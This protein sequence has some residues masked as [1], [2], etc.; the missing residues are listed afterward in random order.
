MHTRLNKLGVC[1]SHKACTLVMKKLREKHDQ[2]VLDWMEGNFTLHSHVLSPCYI[3]QGDNYDTTVHARDMR[4]DN[5]NK[6]LHYFITLTPLKT[7][8]TSTNLILMKKQVLMTSKQLQFLPSC[9]PWK[10]V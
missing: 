6:S 9:L 1:L 3:L 10:T 2:K 5:Q 7:G 8:L 4:M